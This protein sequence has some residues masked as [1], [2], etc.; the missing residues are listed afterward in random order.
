[1][2]SE[3]FVGKSVNNL[4]RERVVNALGKKRQLILGEING[5]EHFGKDVVVNTWGKKG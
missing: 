2:S 1:M 5:T 4:R 3:E